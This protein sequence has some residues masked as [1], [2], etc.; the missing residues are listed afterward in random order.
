MAGT[1]EKSR[2]YR[3]MTPAHPARFVQFVLN[4]KPRVAINVKWIS[5]TE[6][7]NPTTCESS[8]VL[9]KSQER[10]C[11]L[12]ILVV[13]T[14]DEQVLLAYETKNSILDIPSSK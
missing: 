12:S 10:S 14:G 7:H 4:P 13:R 5:T 11:N 8:L 3:A 2:I 6:V 1:E 9:C